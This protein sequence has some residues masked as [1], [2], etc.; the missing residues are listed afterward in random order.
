MSDP[1]SDVRISPARRREIIDALRRGTV[2]QRGLAGS[3]ECSHP[4]WIMKSLI[5]RWK[6]RPS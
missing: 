1:V 5:T 2:P 4:N 3:F 6:C